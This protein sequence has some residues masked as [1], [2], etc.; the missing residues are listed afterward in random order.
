[1]AMLIAW[2]TINAVRYPTSRRFTKGFLI[3]T[4]GITIRD[5]L[6]VLLPN[7]PNAYD[8]KNGLV[9][10]DLVIELHTAVIVVTNFHAFKL[11]ERWELSR[12]GR[13]LLQ[14]RT[15]EAPT[16]LET[17]GQKLQRV[18]P[19]LMGIK[20]PMVMNDEAHHGYREKPPAPDDE[21]ENLTGDARKEAEENNEATALEGTAR[22]PEGLVAVATMHRAK[23]LEYRAAAVIA[24]DEDV[25]PI[26]ERLATASDMSELQEVHETERH[27]L[28]VAVT[29]ARAE[30]WVS[31][32]MPGSDYLADL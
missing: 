5:R 14:G 3:V 13:Q 17:E 20:G 18:M 32:V 9:P 15:G 7:D 4:P 24:C 10:D 29:R 25:L 31:G 16:T 23:G 2:Q 28:Y 1:M 8:R 19:E 12:G 6:Q 11:R 22:P 30:L 26:A 27:L 21:D